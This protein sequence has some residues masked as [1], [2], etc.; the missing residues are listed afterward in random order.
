MFVTPAVVELNLPACFILQCYPSL[1]TVI[2]FP[3]TNRVSLLKCSILWLYLRSCCHFISLLLTKQGI[4]I[5]HKNCF[6]I[7][8]IVSKNVSFNY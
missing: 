7:M 5:S 3:I 4:G 2:F 6:H 8:N 1:V